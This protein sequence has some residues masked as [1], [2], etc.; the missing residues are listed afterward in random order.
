MGGGQRR[1]RIMAAGE[2]AP[3]FIGMNRQPVTCECTR[4][5]KVPVVPTSQQ[6]ES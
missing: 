3:I 1:L 2:R 5:S 4:E 6:Q